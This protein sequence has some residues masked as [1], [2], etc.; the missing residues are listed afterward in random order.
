MVTRIPSL[1]HYTAIRIHDFSKMARCVIIKGK[2][3]ESID[4]LSNAIQFT[5]LIIMISTL[6]KTTF[7]SL[8]IGRSKMS[9]DTVIDIY[10]RWIPV[11]ILLTNH[12]SVTIP[13]IGGSYASSVFLR[14][15]RRIIVG[16][17]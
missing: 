11:G 15:H 10:G 3:V 1:M 13:E 5:Q 17:D 9:R 12:I 8:Q 16:K 4:I 2:Y 14:S 7:R 6:S